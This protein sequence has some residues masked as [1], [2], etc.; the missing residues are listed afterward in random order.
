MDPAGAEAGDGCWCGAGG[1]GVAGWQ[2][3]QGWPAVVEQ[4]AVYNDPAAV[5]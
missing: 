1:Y 3:L 4:G 2:D 5:V